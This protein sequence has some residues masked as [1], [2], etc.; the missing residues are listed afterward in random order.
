MSKEDVLIENFRWATTPEE[1]LRIINNPEATPKVIAKAVIEADTAKEL[2]AILRSKH[3]TPEIYYSVYERNRDYVQDNGSVISALLASPLLT[4]EIFQ[5]AVANASTYSSKIAII[6]SKFADE[7]TCLNIVKQYCSGYGS[8]FGKMDVINAVIESNHMSSKILDEIITSIGDDDDLALLC[9]ESPFL[10]EAQFVSICDLILQDKNTFK[11]T[12]PKI[13]ESQFLSTT[14]LM[15]LATKYPSFVSSNVSKIINS[16]ACNK[17]ILIQLINSY[18]TPYMYQPIIESSLADEEILLTLLDKIKNGDVTF[19]YY[20]TTD[21]IL[22]KI[23]NCP[24]ATPVV[25]VQIIDLTTSTTVLEA[26]KNSPLVNRETKIALTISKERISVA[27][28]EEL[29]KL[30][31]ITE[32]EYLLFLEKLPKYTIIDKLLERDGL[33]N[34]VYKKIVEGMEYLYK[35]SSYRSDN[36]G[37]EAMYNKLVEKDLPEAILCEIVKTVPFFD[38]FSKIAA[39]KNAGLNVAAALRVVADNYSGKQ[40][41]QINKLADDIKRKIIQSMFV[42]EEEH[43]ASEMLR[44]NIEDGLSTMLWGPSGVG[45][46]SRVFEIDPTATML[47]LK[48]G[49]LPEEVIGGREPNGEPGKLYPPHWYEVLCKKCSAEPDRMHVLFID[50]FTNVSDTIKN[51]VWEV[52][53]NRNVHGHEEWTLPANCSIVVAGNRPEEST[54]VKIDSAGGVMP[55]PLHNRID[56]MIEIKFD[57]NEWQRWALETDSKTGKLRIHPIVYSF[58]VAHA[59]DV[60]FTN[61][62]PED[63]TMPFLSPRKWETLS[64]TIYKAEERGEFHHVSNA[65]IRSIIGDNDIATAFIAHYERMPLDMKKVENGEYT[66]DDFMQVEDRLYA[67]G[68]L[69]A[70]YQGDEMAVED[71]IVE[72]L[73]EEYFAIYQSMSGLRKSVEESKLGV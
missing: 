28:I 63:V 73:G 50:E 7:S 56:S 38:I 41:E 62:N 60:M 10:T 24:A 51:L 49:M 65:R 4:E 30:D 6:K 19:S 34:E 71:F 46:S 36:D 48:N 8:S 54:A 57:I 13:F 70:K 1:R 20:P 45:K 31:N 68:I 33:S 66:A 23:V 42:I 27:D 11:K 12:V 53:G 69:V 67:L 32:Q 18:I 14:V 35:R 61:Y 16:S 15:D 52:I 55:A 25:L 39:H 22:L 58:C 5:Y 47:I 72:C 43:D 17:D 29:L 37:I 44:M 3:L 2:V 40:A 26:I 9:M 64:R 59:E 21:E